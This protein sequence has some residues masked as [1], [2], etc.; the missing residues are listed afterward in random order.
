MLAWLLM[1]AFLPHCWSQ[2]CPTGRVYDV[3]SF[4]PRCLDCASIISN[5]MNLS[6]IPTRSLLRK[7]AVKFGPGFPQNG[8]C[9][10]WRTNKVVDV[11][12][13]GSQIVSGVYFLRTS[14]AQ[15]LNEIAVEASNDNTTYIPW[16][17]Y[18]S[19]NHTTAS[20]VLFKLPIRASA[21]RLTILSYVNHF[22]NSTR[23]MNITIQALVSKTQPFSCG[24]PTLP[25]GQCC[26]YMNMTVKDGKCEWCKDPSQ[27]YVIMNGVCGVCKPGTMDRG[28]RCVPSPRQTIAATTL[29]IGAVELD[30]DNT[31]RVALDFA[32]AVMVYVVSPA[33]ERAAHPCET[34][35]T[36][37]CLS[38]R[39]GPPYTLLMSPFDNNPRGDFQFDRGRRWLVMNRDQI[40]S[41]TACVRDLCT[42]V[43]GV[44]YST[45]DFVQVVERRIEY[46]LSEGIP[47][48]VMATSLP[49]RVIPSRVE[50]HTFPDA[51]YMRVDV[52]TNVTFSRFMFRCVG[53]TN[54]TQF[55]NATGMIQLP[56][57]A[58]GDP[59]CT[60]FGV[61][62]TCANHTHK[63]EFV[64]D[65]PSSVV[66]H[67]PL[68]LMPSF[69]VRANMSFGAG[70]RASPL[71]GDTDRLITLLAAS[72]KPTPAVITR[73]AVTIHDQDTVV[74]SSILPPYVMNMGGVCM[75]RD[76]DTALQW[77]LMQLG[78][79]ADMD[80]NTTMRSLF[81]RTCEAART[82]QAFW[83]VIP[84]D[85]YKNRRGVSAYVVSAEIE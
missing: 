6:L 18:S 1:V 64:V 75:R 63:M 43:V 48:F 54:W 15:W 13:N 57:Y 2:Y 44:V 30:K 68:S 84:F 10:C 27:M 73:L 40:R 78:M 5:P 29:G 42:G 28:N 79:I 83:L 67:F 50:V 38:L 22:I 76:F 35:H 59:R 24:C 8:T 14:R 72:T 23:G 41:W 60:R 80:N 62:G 16:G 4:P 56:D 55:F 36:F 34:D 65:R 32:D 9:G 21:L 70:W 74:H 11:F 19:R 20:T 45:G 12:L 53:W 61:I 69:T 39:P 26:P 66:K 58:L 33:V 51:T 3:A 52:S 17:A 85:I 46:Q 49:R 81:D 71:V 82:Q 25:N 47:T 77:L 31:W 7:D 37:R